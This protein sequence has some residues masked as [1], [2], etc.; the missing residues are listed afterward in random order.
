MRAREDVDR[1]ELEHAEPLH[2]RRDLVDARRPRRPRPA[3][4][5][6][7]E[8]D[9]AGARDAQLADGWGL[10][11]R[12]RVGRRS[13]RVPICRVARMGDVESRPAGSG[14]LAKVARRG[15]ATADRGQAA[16]GA[17]RSNEHGSVE[18]AAGKACPAADRPAGRGRGRARAGRPVAGRPQGRQLLQGHVGIDG[19]D[20]CRSAQRVAA[21]RS[22]APQVGDIVLFHPPAGARPRDPLCGVADEGSGHAQPCGVPLP[23]ESSDTFIKRVVAGPGDTV[24]IVDGHA[25]VNG[26]TESEPY[27]EPC[28]AGATTCSFPTPVRVPAGDYYMLGDNRGS[29]TTAASGGRCRAR[30]SSARSCTARTCAR[31]ATRSADQASDRRRPPDCPDSRRPATDTARAGARRTRRTAPAGSR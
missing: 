13:G 20:A 16:S 18:P 30:G 7:R 9:P 8:R 5:L 24:A 17:C 21:D 6:G 25:V 27:I 2:E 26:V 4:A 10:D 19:A 14:W 15:M 3:E 11:R 29:R 23:Q 22:H 12:H 31:C 28:G 1:V